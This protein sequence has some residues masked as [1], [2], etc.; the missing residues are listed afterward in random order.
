[1]IFAEQFDRSMLENINNLSNIVRELTRDRK[2]QLFLHNLLP[3]KRAMLYF[4]QASTR[5]FLSF[6][7]AC[8]LLGMSIAEIRDPSVSSE[9]KGES[10]FDSMRMFSS[11]FDVVIMRT[12]TAGFAEACAYLMNDL[13]QFNE[14]NVP[15]VNG[16]SGS[17]EHPTQALLDIH[18]IQRCFEFASERDSSRWTLFDE[19]R[20]M[21]PDLTRGIDSK[22]FGFCGDI[23]R[24]RTV[25]SLATLLALFSDVTLHFVSPPDL[26]LPPNLRD[27]LL[28]KGVKVFEHDTLG[29]IIEEVDLLYMTRI[30]WEHD[31]DAKAGRPAA[32]N[33]D[34]V[35]T[36]DLANRM[37]SYAPILHPFPRNAEI[38]PEV[39]HNP[40]AM[41]FRQA[42]NGMWVRAALLAHLFDVDGSILA[43]HREAFSTYHDYNVGT[44]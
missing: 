3:E 21:Y 33:A 15:V 14:R 26:G 20:K 16:G 5:T 18:T 35:L 37:K 32:V 19:Y 11:Y 27:S 23:R 39:D 22:V 9:Y 30:Q 7:A 36:P 28:A 25:R 24:G 34:F 41:Y 10:P 12:P 1:M 4:T 40:R 6:Q 29:E 43:H 31:A 42:R 38:P 8:Q 13:D 17:D 2:N 44:A